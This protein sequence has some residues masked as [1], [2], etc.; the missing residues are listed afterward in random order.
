MEPT[1]QPT[2]EPTIPTLDPTENPTQEPSFESTL[3]SESEEEDSLESQIGGDDGMEGI[4]TALAIVGGCFIF[5][6]IVV[7]IFYRKHESDYA[8]VYKQRTEQMTPTSPQSTPRTTDGDGMRTTETHH[9]TQRSIEL[10]TK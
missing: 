9:F 2:V 6:V 3:Y 8:D 4:I 1:Y 5:V 10:T 7:C